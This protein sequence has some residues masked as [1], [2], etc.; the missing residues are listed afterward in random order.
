MLIDGEQIGGGGIGEGRASNADGAGGGGANPSRISKES[1]EVET[2][3]GDAAAGMSELLGDSNLKKKRRARSAA[4]A[5]AG[6]KNVEPSA[7]TPRV[8][9][10]LFA[11]EGISSPATHRDR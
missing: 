7:V 1:F 9:Q 5:A 10:S 2:S 11:L 6:A 8:C 4:L 3:G